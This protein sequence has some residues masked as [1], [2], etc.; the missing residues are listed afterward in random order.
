MGVSKIIDIFFL[1]EN[2][3]WGRLRYSGDCPPSRVASRPGRKVDVTKVHWMKPSN[4]GREGYSGAHRP[5]M[6]PTMRLNSRI[7]SDSEVRSLVVRITE[8]IGPER[9]I[10]LMMKAHDALKSKRIR[11][12]ETALAECRL[13]SFQ[14]LAL[15]VLTMARTG[16]PIAAM[17]LL[18][19]SEMYAY[20]NTMEHAR[21]FFAYRQKI[22]VSTRTGKRVRQLK[23]K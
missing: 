18:F 9:F 13:K 4:R 21:A 10:V 1:T 6:L 5:A 12:A 22:Q 19:E 20:E 2:R 23:H 8:R 17:N 3:R 7:L 14:T 11:R 16:E 15:A